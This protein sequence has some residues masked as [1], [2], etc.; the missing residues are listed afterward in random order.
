VIVDNRPTGVIPGQVVSQAAPD[1]YTLLL[2]G[3]TLWT[4][5]FLRKTSYDVARDFAPI[6]LVETSVSVAAIHP[7]LPV[8][9]VKELIALAQARPGELNYT[10]SGAGSTS[11][12]AMELFKAMANVNIVHVPYKSNSAAMIDLIAG[13]VQVSFVSASSAVPYVKAGRLR[14]LA[15]TSLEPSALAPG[16]PPVAAT[17]SGYEA[18]SMTGMFAPAKTPAPIIKRLNDEISRYLRTPEAKA[19]FLKNGVEP[20]GNT[21]DEFAVIMR[22]EMNRMRKLIAD[23][24]LRL[25]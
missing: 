8:K 10:S 5:T 21:P 17:L 20:V 11:H 3:G 14:A 1:G 24:G 12:L 7:S 16:L 18:V 22:A 13:Q 15:V 6:T 2:S 25:D 23:L 19:L 4:S 9:S